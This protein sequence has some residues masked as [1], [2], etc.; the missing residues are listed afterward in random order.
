MVDGELYCVAGFGAHSDWYRNLVV[1][2]KVEIWLPD[3]RWLGTA[4]DVSGCERRLPLL[5]QVLIGSGAVT[6]LAGID[7]VGLPDET[8]DAV[9]S[10]Y[11]LLHL[12]RAVALTGSGGPGELAWVWPVTAVCLLVLKLASRRWPRRE[13]LAPRAQSPA[14]QA[15]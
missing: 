8:L 6:Y 10:N 3:G 13:K 11:R 2:P 4:E 1:N 14:A 12:Q 15:F 7:P 5:R 9:T